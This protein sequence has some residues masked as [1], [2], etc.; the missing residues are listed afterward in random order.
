[1]SEEFVKCG[2]EGLDAV[3]S[4]LPRGGL[5]VISGTP[6]TGK[7]ALATSLLYYG[8]L[9]CGEPG[10]YASLLED[11]DSFYTYMRTLGYDFERLKIEKKF[12]YI[13]LPTMLEPG[14]ATGISMV[15]NTVK[16]LGAGR[17]VID[18]YTAMSQMFKDEG[19]ARTFLHT[20]VSK[21]VKQLRCTTILVKEEKTPGEKTEYDFVDFIADGV[22]SLEMNTFEDKRVRRLHIIKMRGS[23]LRNPRICFTLH[24]GFTPLLPTRP[25]EKPPAKRI[26]Y[27]ADPPGGYTTG[28]PDLDREIG[29]IPDKSTIMFEVDPRLTPRE[30]NVVPMPIAASFIMKERPCLVLPTGGVTWSVLQELGRIYGLSEEHF[31]NY[32]HV[33]A[34]SGVPEEETNLIRLASDEQMVNRLVKLGSS[35][36]RKFKKPI[37][38]VYGIDRLVSYFAEKTIDMIYSMQD[39]VRNRPGINMWIVKPTR[40]WIA[41]S[42][43]PLADMHF[44]ITRLHGTTIVYGLK[45]RTPLYAVQTTEETP[46]PKIIPIT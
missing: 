6:G 12:S 41:R 3:I 37:I 20:I 21:M 42:L 45:P 7:T 31:K 26:K 29:S 13:A 34:E 18:S 46:I 9:K 35:L 25:P 11:E 38:T 43:A 19:E 16:S 1:V 39:E 44:K 28:I 17:L 5:I 32:L 23:E 30:Y 14:I 22:I 2:I 10:V 40:P 4:G 36:S 27:P 24:G 8:A 15:M 33:I